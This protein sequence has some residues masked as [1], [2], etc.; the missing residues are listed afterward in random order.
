[1]NKA[2]KWLGGLVVALLVVVAGT[3]QAAERSKDFLLFNGQSRSAVN[4]T[5]E[6]AS[7][8]IPI[9]GA[10]RVVI[11]TFSAGAATD[12]MYADSLATFKV[13]FSDSICCRVTGSDGRTIP[14]AADSIMIDAALAAAYDTTKINVIVGRPLPIGKALKASANASGILTPVLPVLPNAITIDTSPSAVINKNWMRVRTLA[15]IRLTTAG[16]SSTAGIRTSG[17]RALKM[18]ATVYYE[19]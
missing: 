18:I 11:R 10:K 6:Y 17:V 1:M 19:N 14:S 15:L 13:L 7:D 16:F 4:D 3:A 12:T 8:W 2:R 9:K 5:S